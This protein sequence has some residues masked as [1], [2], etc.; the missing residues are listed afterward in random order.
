[1]IS[2]QSLICTE[3]TLQSIP[4][5]GIF[6]LA[7]LLQWPDLRGTRPPE[8]SCGWRV[9]ELFGSKAGISLLDAGWEQGLREVCCL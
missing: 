6:E 8:P 5:A 1:M 3:D 7:Q 4:I 2:I 9:S